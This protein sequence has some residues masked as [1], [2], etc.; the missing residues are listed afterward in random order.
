MTGV[1]ARAG[2]V[3]CAG[4]ALG[5]GACGLGSKQVL[6]DRVINAT[7]QLE[8]DGTAEAALTIGIRIVP[9]KKPAQPGPARIAA[10]QLPALSALVDLRNGQAA[11]GVQNG[12]AGTAALLFLGSDIYERI[13]PK[14][15]TAGNRVRSQ[16]ASNLF[17]L[18]AAGNPQALELITRRQQPASPPAPPGLP[19]V[20]TTTTT[21]A[22]TT[23]T[24]E[25]ASPLRRAPRVPR[26]WIAFDYSK[27]KDR[28]S[29]KRAGS[30][31]ISPDA[32]LRLGNGVLT[33]S[34]KRVGVEGT[35]ED[36]LV[37]YDANVN[38]DKAERRLSEQQKKTLDKIFK[39]NAVSA[40]VFK[41]RFWLDGHGRLRRMA[42]SLRQSLTNIDRADLNLT[43]DIT[44]TG[45]PVAIPVP[46]PKATAVVGSLG[47]LVTSVSA[48]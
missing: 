4:L 1:R 21:T 23:T 7:H 46:D 13:P 2:A 45:V 42:V 25:K 9:G 15:A 41:A 30:Y 3:A 12:D 11:V 43:I 33:G 40:R 34:I 26:Q 14:E 27:I 36:Q 20:T 32:I 28:D 10:F 8:A 47:Q 6:A 39:A 5:M 38:R 18:I 35:G 29:T 44:K 22:P 19:A 31:A 48:S 37:R 17:P 16:A 24:T